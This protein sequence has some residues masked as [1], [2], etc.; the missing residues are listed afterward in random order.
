M[1]PLPYSHYQPVPLSHVRPSGWILEFLKRQC[2]GITGNLQASGFPLDHT[3]WGSP[4]Q[5]PE[6]LDPDMFW[7]PYEQTA[8]RIDG[9]LRPLPNAP[10]IT[11][12]FT[13]KFCE[14][15]MNELQR[16]RFE[17]A[18]DALGRVRQVRLTG[19]P[20]TIAHLPRVGRRWLL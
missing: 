10:R 4:N 16:E 13:E 11:P 1:S 15:I 14:Q 19:F 8:Y 5:S 9:A 7:W 12:E 20:R 6:V 17:K 2:T 18:R 3:F